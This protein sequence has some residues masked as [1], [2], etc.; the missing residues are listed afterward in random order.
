MRNLF[1]LFIILP[2][3]VT[4]KIPV[5]NWDWDFDWDWDIFGL[6]D[7][8]KSGVPQFIKDIQTN[9]KKFIEKTE[10]QKNAYIAE[11]NTKVTEL[12]Q[13]IKKE[14]EEKKELIE[15]DLKSLVEKVTEA[16]NFLSYKI[17][18]MADM[19][20]E[21][22]RNDKKKVFSNLL[23]AVKENF[24]QCSS[25]INQISVLTESPENGLKY[26]LF[27]VN[28]LSENPDA[29]EQGKSQ[30]IYDI[31][32]CL[33]EKL[34]DYWPMIK[35]KLSNTD[36]E[37]NLKL[38]IINLLAKSFSNLI[39]VIEYEELDGYIKKVSNTTGLI[40]EEKA[41]KIHQ[42]IFKIIKRLSDFGTQF[43]NI[44]DTLSVNV[45]VN[46][47]SLEAELDNKVVLFENKEK[48]I[49][50]KL[51]SNYMLRNLQAS[52]LQAVVFDSPFVSVRGSKEN[53]GGIS[54]TF[55]GITLYDK[56]HNE[57]IVKDIDIEQFRPEIL[58]KKSLFKAM[59]HCLFYNEEKNS[60]ENDGVASSTE[61]ING[62]EYIKCIPKHLTSFAIASYESAQIDEVE[63]ESKSNVV[64]I[65]VAVSV[66]VVALLIGGF[67]LYR[68]LRRK[69]IIGNS[70][71][72]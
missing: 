12:Y 31:L 9:I 15:E 20:Y 36:L 37:F 19:S 22:C 27:L 58:F 62:I 50:I 34:D 29:I 59:T 47:G 10:D 46:P 49:Q 5:L 6:L 57:I 35:A 71:V 56:D 67:F 33:Q 72:Y 53:E 2:L 3:I 70:K 43:Y 68:F 30:I 16:S 48:G 26:I 51:H 63:P 17:C 24:G 52:S 60:M 23:N 4:I 69:N 1:S 42:G 65:A 54:K 13:K 14:A 28:S 7:F 21:E 44:S 61:I 18:D 25:I 45:I 11:L 66:S 39:N 64:I 38:D 55:V 41:K 8:F 32:N 40:S